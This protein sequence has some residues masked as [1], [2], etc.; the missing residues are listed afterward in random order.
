M[1]IIWRKLFRISLFCLIIF[2]GFIYVSISSPIYARSYQIENYDVD[3][4][5]NEDSSVDVTETA[6]YYFTQGEFVGMFR[7][8]T[9][10]DYE[11]E[12]ECNRNINLTC[13]GFQFLKL[14]NV[15][16]NGE[17]IS[18]D[19]YETSII[20]NYSERRFRI[21][22]RFLQ[23]NEDERVDV[24]GERYTFEINYT[25]WGAL[26]FQD[27]YVQFYWDTL[28]PD[29]DV[30]FNNAKVT[31]SYPSEINTNEIELS[32]TNTLLD[33]N[34]QILNNSV[35]YE[36]ENVASFY[37]FTLNQKL[38]TGVIRQP[39]NLEINYVLPW[40]NF[41]Q[42]NQILEVD[43]LNN[44]PL[45]INI[46]SNTNLSGLP[47]GNYDIKLKDTLFIKSESNQIQIEPGETTAIELKL[48]RTDFANALLIIV[49]VVNIFSILILFASFIYYSLRYLR[50]RENSISPRV[51]IPE[52][53]PPNG[54][55]SYLL[56]T[57]ID[58]TVDPRDVTSTI[59][60]LAYRGFIK[61]TELKKNNYRLTRLKKDEEKNELNEIELYLIESI[62]GKRDQTTTDTLKYSFA[63]K[64]KTLQVKIY[65]EVIKLNIFSRNP[66]NFRNTS[67][68]VGIILVVI[69]FTSLI[70]L[71]QFL[72]FGVSLLLIFTGLLTFISR[73]IFKSKTT[74][75]SEFL[76][77]LLGFK[78][79]LETAEK[80]R[81]QELTPE[82][83]EKYLSYAVAFK[84][85]KKWAKK[86]KDLYTTPPDWYESRSDLNTFNSLLLANAL[87]DF[88]STTN[89][90]L[91]AT[92]SSG[93]S[94][95]TGGGWSG[96]GGFSG[97]FSGGGAGGGGG[98]A[99]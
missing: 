27:D 22:Y 64:Y 30:P 2:A 56:G 41:A 90:N 55:Q 73:F 39:G 37:D 28:Y 80:Y 91:V 61:I 50:N 92:Q 96:G 74:T 4:T 69:G 84:V 85:E 79:Y 6:D 14:N 70:F 33:Y 42:K 18:S 60:D 3:I 24:T 16:V 68:A 23:S 8:I 63:A 87:S 93:S 29:R 1:K 44:I 17:T 45:D 7:E 81:L 26:N 62:F 86:F 94:G 35:R 57:V 31:V 97:G 9:L 99:W 53:K 43:S 78:K 12:L 71:S 89:N 59:I 77:R 36:L 25:A 88:S 34:E 15:K 82:T 38:P 98:G 75:G 51:V 11:T 5:I 20:E 54:S 49:I 32:T 67:T 95:G 52:F 46:K 13:G 58:E 47:S 19:R 10:N 72:L 76:R 48:S 83:F 21:Q 65:K 66:D 40:P